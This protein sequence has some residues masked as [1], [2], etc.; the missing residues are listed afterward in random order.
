MPVFKDFYFESTT[1]KNMIHALRCDPD[2]EPRGIVQ[3]AHG[4]AEYVARYKD[5][6]S[7]L[8]E[9]GFIAVGNDHLGHGGSVK[10]P[11]EKGHF[12]DDK[13][14]EY[15]VGDMHKLYET[16]HSEHPELPYILFG[17]SM[18]SFLS[19]TFIIQYPELLNAC[20]LSGT[21]HQG[22]A[23]LTGGVAMSTLVKKI[24]GP[25]HIANGLNNVAFG[26]YNN[27]YENPKT[28]FD[29]LNRDPAEVQKY[30][31][32]PNCGF[33]CTAALYNDMMKG[34][35]FITSPSN[36]AKMR[37]DLPIYFMSGGAD[38]VGENGKGVNKAYNAFLRAGMKDVMIRIYPEGRH[39]MLNEINRKD[40][41]NDI[42]NWINS[43]I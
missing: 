24:K 43:K 39:E 14:W 18:G 2:T 21:G 7:F 42:L 32:D 9:N 13:G 20:I 8:A 29:W 11:G 3:I 19:R 41:Y 37:K 25:R 40:V 6:M 22:K 33:V 15:V 26:S 1:G 23:L 5:F 31:D 35:G 16:M 28:A 4:I 12:A 36:I 27:G 34:I 30:I 17:H 38:P 10:E